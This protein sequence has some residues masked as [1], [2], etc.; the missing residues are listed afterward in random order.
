MYIIKRFKK[1]QGKGM[2]TSLKLP[3][4]VNMPLCAQLSIYPFICGSSYP[5]VGTSWG[6]ARELTMWGRPGGNWRSSCWPRGPSASCVSSGASKPR[7]RW[8]VLTRFQRSCC[9]LMITTAGG[10]VVATGVYCIGKQ[11]ISCVSSKEFIKT[12]GT[13]SHHFNCLV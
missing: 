4:T 11:S 8:V 9:E 1:V 10:A 2:V 7:E 6:S 3:I 12:T 13:E 5:V